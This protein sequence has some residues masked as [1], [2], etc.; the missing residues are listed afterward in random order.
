M[1]GYRVIKFHF[2]SNKTRPRMRNPAYE[3]TNPINPRTG[4]HFFVIC[5]GKW[6]R[7]GAVI[8]SQCLRPIDLKS[9]SLF[10]T[11][12]NSTFSGFR[13]ALFDVTMFPAAENKLQFELYCNHLIVWSYRGFIKSNS[14][15]VND[16][17]EGTYIYISQ[18]CRDLHFFLG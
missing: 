5:W 17:N 8:S 18:K 3:V 14:D 7:T 9:A 12:Y 1:T 4:N 6:T 13:F 10:L 15:D 11:T 16:G 2:E